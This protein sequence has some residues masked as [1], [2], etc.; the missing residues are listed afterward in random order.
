[1]KGNEFFQEVAKRPP[2]SKLHPAMGGFLADYLAHEKV[3]SFRGRIVVNTNFPPYPSP[4]FDNLVDN[5][6]EIGEAS[7][8]RLYSVTLAVTNRCNFKCWHCYNAGR[9]EEDLSFETLKRVATEIQDM[10]AVMVTLTGGEPLLRNDLESIVGLFDAR[11]CQIVGTTGA[12]LTRKRAEALRRG[13]LFGVGISLDSPEEA[14]HDR[15][16][17]VKGAFQIA[18]RG[19][20]AAA[21][22]G[23]YPYV[24]AVARR[25]LLE[26]DRFWRF[27]RFAGEAGALEMHL[28]E[29]SATGRLAGRTDV[30]LD[31]ADRKRIVAYQQEA[32]RDDSLPILSSY[33]YLEGGEAF[34]CGAGLTHLYIDGSGEV[35][36]CQLVPLSFGNVGR[37]PLSAILDRMG[38]HFTRPRASC[39]GR[40]LSPHVPEG[41]LPLAPE[42]SAGICERCLPKEHEVPRFFRVRAAAQ[43]EVGQAELEAAYDRVH[44]DYDRFWLTEAA[45]P[46]ERLAARL[47]LSKCR[48]VFE[49]GCGTGYATVLLA[50]RLPQTGQLVAADLSEGMLAEARQRVAS[51]GL[52]NVRFLAGDALALLEKEGPVDLVF[53]SWVLGY[54][55]L[56][57][58][59]RAASRALRPGGRLAFVVHKENSPRGPLEI[60]GE[61][62]ARDPSV[63]LKRVAFD[64][65]RGMDHVRSE[66]DAAGLAVEDLWE[67]EVVFHCGTAEAVLEH[68]LKSGAGTAFYDAVD[69]ARRGVLEKEFL[70]RLAQRR[71]AG[72]SF[73]VIHDYVACIARKT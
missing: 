44:A 16:R 63:L 62:V 26:R 45:K 29:P 53:S 40:I 37:E 2:F 20:R 7:R 4:A 35:C 68:L 34:G 50:G 54:I 31:D 19:L 70:S 24:V 72:A 22:A 48:K 66:M 27:L 18:L 61:I 13:G 14:E 33:T 15:L 49:A 23:L 25:D 73:D 67:G 12:G 64:F 65:P 10:G 57:P 6:A 59:F 5:F 1:M 55:P 60:F 58:F 41:R 21:E 28:L 42:A 69:P 11:A 39:V 17:G 56:K 30:A 43:G 51:A 36:P 9:S 32:A 38:R 71:G 52:R 47:D 46:T 3:V 8:R